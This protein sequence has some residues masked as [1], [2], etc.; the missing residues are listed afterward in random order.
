MVEDGRS[1]VV[2]V[3]NLF[4]FL[5]CLALPERLMTSEN[6]INHLTLCGHSDVF[7]FLFVHDYFHQLQSKACECL[8]GDVA[9]GAAPPGIVTN[10]SSNQSSVQMYRRFAV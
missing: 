8:N 7:F 3:S 6:G 10:Q 9:A 2:V 1:L 4:L 5:A